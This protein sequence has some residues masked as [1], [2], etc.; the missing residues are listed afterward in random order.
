MGPLPSGRADI[1][2][3]TNVV[4]IG[5]GESRDV[6]F[7][8]PPHSGGSGPDVYLFKNR[9]ADKLTNPG[10]PGMGGMATEV[11]VYPAGTLPAQSTPNETYAVS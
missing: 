9:N 8:A 10:V 7:T 6:L 3:Y 2:Y 1:T 11:R 4:Y 5:P